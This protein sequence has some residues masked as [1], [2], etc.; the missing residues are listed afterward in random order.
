MLTKAI[1]VPFGVTTGSIIVV[2]HDNSLIQVFE[3]DFTSNTAPVANDDFVTTPFN[4]TLSD[5]NV[6]L[7]DTDADLDTLNI[8]SVTT[9]NFGS[10]VINGT[11]DGIDYTPDP[12]FRGV[13]FFNYTISDGNG[14]IDEATVG[15]LVLGSNGQ[16]VFTSDRDG[17]LEIY[18]MN[19]DG[20]GQTNISND[21]DDDFEPA[22]SPNGT[23]I[24]FISNRTGFLEIHIM[25]ADGSGV[26]Q[27]TFNAGPETVAPDWSPNGTKLVYSKDNGT[28]LKL[29]S[30]NTDGTGEAQ[31]TSTGGNN[32]FPSWSPDDE[33]IA[34]TDDSSISDIHV[35]DLETFEVFAL[36]SGE[37]NEMPAWTVDGL[38]ILYDNATTGDSEIFI[39]DFFDSPSPTQITTNLVED[40]DPASS[41][42]GTKIVFVKGENSAAEIYTMNF[43]GSGE[44]ALTS[45]GAG[46]FE[47]DWSPNTEIL[48]ESN[49]A[50]VAFDDFATTYRNTAVV[51]NATTNDSD[52]DGDTLN[53]TS[54]TTPSDGTADINARWRAE[55]SIT[56]TKLTKLK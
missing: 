19:D 41:P 49:T 43:D 12:D 26:S 35:L 17:N 30:I 18:V 7:N 5:I 22:W 34:F 52:A 29:F 46:D 48:S 42:N 53:V 11:F 3:N 44:V 50:P 4:T 54:V 24:A 13:D 37:D 28:H 10:A 25:D 8:T 38:Q 45:N 6:L 9:P 14:G 21:P 2:D 39:L 36:T 31:L 55:G 27:V 40:H 15:V 23:K 47:P 33:F 1:F 32:D 51:I 56:C 16:I 20:T